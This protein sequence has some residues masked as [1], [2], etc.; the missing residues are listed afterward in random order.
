MSNRNVYMYWIG[1][2]CKLITLLRNLIYLHSTNGKGY[3]V[4]MI[5]HENVNEYVKDLPAC[6]Y[7][8]CPAHQADVVRVNV[9]SDKGGIWLDSDTLVLDKLD[10][11]FDLLET[12]DGL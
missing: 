9:I 3:N 5:N 4:H 2:E 7:K 12:G 1:P 6:F 11:L 8:L 10:T